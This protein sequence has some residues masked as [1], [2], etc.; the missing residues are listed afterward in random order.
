LCDN[1]EEQ[2][3]KLEFGESTNH[4]PGHTLPFYFTSNYVQL[5]DKNRNSDPRGFHSIAM[6]G[7]LTFSI[8]TL[9]YSNKMFLEH[10][11]FRAS[12]L[13]LNWIIVDTAGIT[14]SYPHARLGVSLRL[15]PER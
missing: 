11:V 4:P 2:E 9:I 15:P 1:D 5:P 8:C 12:V 14:S 3:K 10:Q 13:R 7:Q 6:S